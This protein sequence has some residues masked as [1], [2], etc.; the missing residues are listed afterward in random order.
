MSPKNTSHNPRIFISAALFTHAE[1]VFNRQIRDA[2][3]QAGYD[4]ILPQEFEVDETGEGIFRQC[5][6]GV[7]RADLMLSIV[8]GAEVD[9]GVGFEMGYAYA[10][11]I[12]IIAL[13]TDF[14]KRAETIDGGL[15][16]MLHYGSREVISQPQDPFQAVVSA[17]NEY[18]QENQ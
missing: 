10:K 1:Q 16:I 15:N 18:F 17:T 4:V 5:I 14:R 13:R 2:L 11:D 6:A 9:A 8:D 3:V 12:P 7:E